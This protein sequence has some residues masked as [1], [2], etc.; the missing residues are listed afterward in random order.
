VSLYDEMARDHARDSADERALNDLRRQLVA[1]IADPPARCSQ[2]TL[3]AL[4]DA[5]NRLAE[6]AAKVV[7]AWD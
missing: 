5:A 7:R 2:S 3:V 1:F 4:G 6:D